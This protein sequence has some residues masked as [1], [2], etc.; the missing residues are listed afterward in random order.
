MFCSFTIA[1]SILAGI[2]FYDYKKD[3]LFNQLKENAGTLSKNLA[4]NASA[5]ILDHEGKALIHSDIKKIGDAVL[6]E[7]SFQEKPDRPE[8]NQLKEI[9]PIVV[10]GK[11][12]GTVHC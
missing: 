5:A 9:K 2:T 7:N 3:F 6:P 10:N 12:I 11:K 1:L 8:K 4:I